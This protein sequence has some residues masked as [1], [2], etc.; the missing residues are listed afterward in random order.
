[1]TSRR[2]L[3]WVCVGAAS[4]ALAGT[5]AAAWQKHQREGAWLD[6]VLAEGEAIRRSGP[7]TVHYLSDRTSISA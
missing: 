6:R 2:F 4:G 1:M 7:G 5:A 3:G